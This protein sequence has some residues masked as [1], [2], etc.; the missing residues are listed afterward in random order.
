VEE[1]MKCFRFRSGAAPLVCAFLFAA[2]G[3]CALSP[4]RSSVR[5]EPLAASAPSAGARIYDK[6]CGDCHSTAQGPG[7][8]ALQ[9]KYKGTVP[10][11]LNQRNNLPADYVKLVV[12]RGISFMPSFRKTEIS[13]A[14]LALVSAY[15]APK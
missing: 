10:A 8:L 5:A 7:S 13:D 9:R 3:G 11:V 12:R 6:W 2:L 4:A 15:L 14:E 1:K